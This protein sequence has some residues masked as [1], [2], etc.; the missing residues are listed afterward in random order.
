MATRGF[1]NV[2]EGDAARMGRQNFK[3]RVTDTTV[4]VT[5]RLADS[6]NELTP[7][8]VKAHKYRAISCIVTAD[9]TLF[10]GEDIDRILAQMQCET[11]QVKLS[12]K[13]KAALCGVD[14][15][16][17]GSLKEAHR[18]IELSHSQRAASVRDLRRQVSFSLEVNGTAIGKWI[19]DF[20]YE[21]WTPAKEWQMIREDS[22]GIRTPMYKR[23]KAHV[24]AQYGFT[25]RET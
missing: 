18:W 9:L 15:E 8:K 2:T 25:I 13:Q 11:S 19:A 17:F 12:L 5:M 20:V 1:E 16:W 23:S 24:E 7:V 10:T 14:G 6:Y 4:G 21:E 3:T 22:K